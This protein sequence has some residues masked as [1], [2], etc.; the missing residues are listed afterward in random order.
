MSALRLAVILAAALLLG[1]C[2]PT[3]S[4]AEVEAPATGSNTVGDAAAAP[5]AERTAPA[6]P[7]TDPAKIII[8]EA[9]ITDRPYKVLG[10]ISVTVNKTT[11]LDRDPTREVA[12]QRLKEEAAKLGADA[13]I[14][15]RY[16]TVGI[17]LLSWGSL[18]GKGRAVA[19][20]KP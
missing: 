18:D 19:F 14:L 17:G 16:G 13:V 8:T 6:R 4:T 12:A 11:I 20:T 9:D 1:A 2:G 7:K 10:D 3:W 5:Q 15:V